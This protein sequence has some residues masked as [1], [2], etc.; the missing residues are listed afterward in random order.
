MFLENIA[1]LKFL[2]MNCSIFSGNVLIVA[3]Y[4]AFIVGAT[5]SKIA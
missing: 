4:N 3:I 2:C 1:K 5:V